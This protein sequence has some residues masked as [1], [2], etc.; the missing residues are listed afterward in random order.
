MKLYHHPSRSAGSQLWCDT[1]PTTR[2]SRARAA[3]CAA[4]GAFD[5]NCTESTIFVHDFNLVAHCRFRDRE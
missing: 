3:S 2:A 5:G 1:I 4:D